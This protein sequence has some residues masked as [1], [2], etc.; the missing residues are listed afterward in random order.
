MKKTLALILS[1]CLLLGMSAGFASAAEDEIPTLRWVTVG[2]GMPGNYD[3][4]LA[5]INPYLEEKIG[6]HIDVEV[7][8]W[9]D[10]DNRRSVIINT[11]EYYDIIFGNQNVY[12]TDVLIGAYLDLGDLLAEYGQDLLALIPDNYWDAVRV[13]G[14]IYSV[15][16]YK[17]SSQS[18]FIVWDSEIVE[19]LGLDAASATTFE[20]MT[21]L[22]EQVQEYLGTVDGKGNAA[23][24]LNM[25]S[26]ASYVLFEYDQM[27]TGLPAIGVRFDDSEG[28]VVAVLEQDDVQESLSYLHQW[29]NAGIINADAATKPEDE[30][31]KPVS[32]AQGWAG[33]AQT[34]WGPNMGMEAAEA[35]QWKD[36]I[37]SNETVRGSLNMISVNSNYPEKA[38]QFLNL[39]NSDAYVRDL[40]YYGEEGVN[41][42]YMDDGFVNKI[43]SD[44]G[45]AGY[46]QGTFFIVTPQNLFDGYNEWDEVKELNEKAKPSVLLGFTFDTSSVS[47]QIMNCTEIW[48][49][50]KGELMSGTLDPATGVA[51]MMTDMRA[52]GFDDIVAE[53]QAQVDAFLGK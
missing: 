51:A 19:A 50:Y 18:E 39:I 30:N 49:R 32:I 46:T 2:N 17:D 15:P 28:K 20:A 31:Y 34:T 7:V 43:N 6:A 26:G 47:D 53:A 37:V 13:N 23:F 9:G 1:L 3:A 22:L 40:F 29:F 52:S 5:Q 33:A 12:N 10:W 8:A 21:P 16:T 27:N 35:Y 25:N 11:N 42:E 4:W 44:F 45:M 24:P 14:N 36:T 38:M 41:W 48:N